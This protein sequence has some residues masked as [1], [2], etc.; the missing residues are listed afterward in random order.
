MVFDR[1]GCLEKSH[2]WKCD[3][4]FRKL[5]VYIPANYVLQ[6]LII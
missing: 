1:Q 5:Y 6:S 3:S 2:E 4:S